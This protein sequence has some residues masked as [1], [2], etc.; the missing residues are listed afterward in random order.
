MPWKPGMT[1]FSLSPIV[2][3]SMEMHHQSMMRLIAQ[4]HYQQEKGL[5]WKE[6]AKGILDGRPVEGVPPVEMTGGDP[7]L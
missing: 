5:M 7:S 3:Q 6:W 2:F 1:Y 4:W